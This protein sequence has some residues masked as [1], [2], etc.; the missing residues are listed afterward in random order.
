MCV[1]V[2]DIITT[3]VLCSSLSYVGSALLAIVCI[4]VW[5][6]FIV[7]GILLLLQAAGWLQLSDVEQEVCF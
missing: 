7:G 5:V 2:S 3:H 1:C 6:G 4:V